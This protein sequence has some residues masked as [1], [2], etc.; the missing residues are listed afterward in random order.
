MKADYE[1]L[2]YIIQ[3]D[4]CYTPYTHADS[5]NE[6]KSGGM[7]DASKNNAKSK[8]KLP[9]KPAQ[10]SKKLN[11]SLQSSKSTAS[12]GLDKDTLNSM[13]NRSMDD[14]NSSAENNAD[15][16]SDE[17]EAESETDYS[18]MSDSESDND[19]D[20][21][22]DFSVNDCHSR[23]AKKIKKRKIQTKRLASKKRRRSTIDLAASD[24]GSTPNRKKSVKLPKKSLNTSTKSLTATSPIVSIASKSPTVSSTP[25][26]TKVSYI[27]ETPQTSQNDS[28]VKTPNL[29][30]TNNIVMPQATPITEN[31]P[32]SN[33]IIVKTKEKKAQTENVLLSDM[34]S[35]FTPD[36]IKNN[37]SENIIN[38]NKPH[39]SAIVT[40]A[41]VIESISK[42]V[43]QV[44]QTITTQNTAARITTI[45]KL[46]KSPTVTFRKVQKSSINLASEQ[47]KQLDL[48]DSL[49]QEELRKS[50]DT[51]P[52]SG[53]QAVI[54]AAIPNIVKML[55]TSE[56]TS[57]LGNAEFS[58]PSSTSNTIPITYSTT[59]PSHDAQM[60]PDDL[61]ESFVNSD[62]LSDDLMQHVAKL[63][64]DKNLQE[65]IDQQ[66]LGVTTIPTTTLPH[67]QIQTSLA[68]PKS[69]IHAQIPDHTPT[70]LTDDLKS[71]VKTPT[72]STLVTSTSFKEGIRVKRADGR[73]ITLPPIEAP[74]TRGAKRRAETTPGSEVQKKQK[75]FTVIVQTEPHSQNQQKS[76]PNTTTFQSIKA[77]TNSLSKSIPIAVR[78]R[79]AS[80]AVKRASLDTKPRR[81]LS[82]S[83]P[84]VADDEDDDEED[85]SDGSY[86]SEDDP[87]R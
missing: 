5:T 69:N 13:H 33:I 81:S 65:V 48:I 60:L 1:H 64:E 76:Q 73:I 61:L 47:D 86:N 78:E 82:I 51:I 85:G 63:V 8:L 66:V 44:I 24:D 16:S 77:P 38:I 11:R 4:H 26:I 50:G 53:S 21:D 12:N 68:M 43:T 54:P 20:S 39:A 37:S 23:R 3:N 31:K 55:E 29:Q 35:L 27:K 6:G 46:V 80:V 19:R 57:S 36:V 71:I 41:V 75:V 59:Q 22:L 18:E 52:T 40:K 87:H 58:Q 15:R 45:P 49:V 9:I 56:A 30:K 25:R 42:P 62:Y 84:P 74:T 79:R 67:P 28:L 32:K 2:R 14:A 17:E 7:T 72:T 34:S 10:M 70:K 83:N